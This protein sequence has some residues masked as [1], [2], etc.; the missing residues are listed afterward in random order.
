MLLLLACGLLRQSAEPLLL[1]E[2]LQQAQLQLLQQG[3]LKPVQLQQPLP[4]MM[5]LVA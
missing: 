2:R 5:P 3:Q 4:L 1:L